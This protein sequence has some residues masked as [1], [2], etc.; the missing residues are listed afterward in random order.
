MIQIKEEGSGT[1]HRWCG[2]VVTGSAM[3]QDA[4]GSVMW[5][6]E[7]SGTGRGMGGEWDGVEGRGVAMA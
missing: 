6:R 7:A 1:R 5:P 4:G 2:A 3:G